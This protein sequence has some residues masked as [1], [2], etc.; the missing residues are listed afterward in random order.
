MSHR[1][2]SFSALTHKTTAIRLINNIESLGP[3]ITIALQW[4]PGHDGIKGNKRANQLATT[5]AQKP[6][7]KDK[8]DK[9][10]FASFRA[11]VQDWKNKAT[12]S[13]YSIQDIKR[14]GHTPRPKEH[15]TCLTSLKNKHSV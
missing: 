9:P 11:A 5:A 4:W 15:L 7:P 3:Q 1:K 2:T 8:T 12:I 6:L 13:S 14:L 10:M